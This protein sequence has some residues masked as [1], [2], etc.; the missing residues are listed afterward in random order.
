MIFTLHEFLSRGNEYIYLVEN[1]LFF[2]MIALLPT[3]FIFVL[4]VFLFYRETHIEYQRYLEEDR[5]GD[6]HLL[7]EFERFLKEKKAIE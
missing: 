2:I 1:Q 7:R 5:L 3:L 6:E 4:F